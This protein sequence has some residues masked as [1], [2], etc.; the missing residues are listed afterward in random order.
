MPTYQPGL[1]MKVSSCGLLGRIPEAE[2]YM[3]R[4]LAV[5]PGVTV[6]QQRAYWEKPLQRSAHALE[7]H[8]EGL[9]RAG[10]PEA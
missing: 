2:H 1:R 3:R 10:L 8:L 9:R 7:A 5:N 6:A 4:L